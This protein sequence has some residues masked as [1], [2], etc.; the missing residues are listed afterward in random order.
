[1]TEI[2]DN[3]VESIVE[4]T[5]LKQNQK[6][7]RKT[8]L[9]LSKD[10]V[11]KSYLEK[12]LVK[13]LSNKYTVAKEYRPKKKK[14]TSR[15]LNI[16]L[17]DLHYGARLNK[18]EFPIKYTELE[19]S[20][21][22]AAVVDQVSQYKLQ[23]RDETE[24]V[25]HLLG[26][27]IQNQL[28]DPRDGVPLA[29]Q[30]AV[31][32]HLLTQAI[33]YWSS[34]FKKVTVYC[35]P[36]NH[37][38]NKIRHP[39]RAVSQKWDSIETVVYYSIKTACSHIKNINIDIPYTSY[40]TYKLFQMRGFATHGDTVF[41]PGFPGRTI[42]IKNLKDRIYEINNEDTGLAHFN[43]FL[44]GHVHVHSTVKLSNDVTFMSN[45]CL[46]PADAFLQSIG[47]M[48]SPCC[49]VLWE[50][51]PGYMV[52]DRREIVLDQRVDKDKS[53]DKLIK[54]FKNF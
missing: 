46:I 1:M 21:R 19:E 2:L 44:V 24:L 35:T 45:G 43:L 47:T 48:T 49:Q 52:G 17:G 27:I 3:E 30:C 8:E 11:F 18:K 38:R 53:F 51:V 54:P 33:V 16:A 6:D 32:I 5:I 15:V 14:E 31:A 7:L 29:E 4:K 42:N 36:G 12:N 41:C 23:Y 10:L 39:E 37:G 9:A 26:D 34:Q 25:V 13:V 22:T 50:T 28:H 40:Y 20:R